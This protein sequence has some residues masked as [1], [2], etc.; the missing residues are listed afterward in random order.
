MGLGRQTFK[1]TVIY[2]IATAIG[3]LASF[4]MLPFY[5]HIF[6]AQGYGIIAM[7]DS[8]LGLLT[9]LLAGGFQTAILRIYHEQNIENKE[10]T[11][12]TGIALVWGLALLIVVFPLIFSSSI[13]ELILGSAEYYPIILLALITLVIDVAGQSASTIQIIKQQSLLFS[14]INLIQLI[15]GLLL[16]IWLVIFLEVGLI[17]IFISSLTTVMISSLIFHAIAFREHGFGFNLDIVLQLLK[18]QLPLLPGEIISFLGRQAERILVRVMIGLEEVGIL[19]MAYKFPPLIGLFVTIPFQRA[20]RTKSIEIAEQ[21]D[22][23][24]IISEMFTRYL[25]TIVFFGLLLG[26]TIQTILQLT[27][28]AEFWPA[29]SIAKIEIVTTILAGSTSYLSFGILYRKKTMVLSIIRLILTPTKILFSFVFIFI[30]GL[31]GAAYSA[32]LVEAITLI[33]ILLKAQSLYKLPLEYWKIFFIVSGA[34]ILFFVID[35]A[36]HPGIG[37]VMRIVENWISPFINFLRI[38][39]LEGWVS[40][41]IILVLQTKQT[42][43]SLLLLKIIFT[44]SFLILFPLVWRFQ[45]ERRLQRMFGIKII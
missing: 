11:L 19:E 45:P 40:E 1:H 18:F 10:I 33:W 31:K 42:Q 30:W 12:G 23:P 4:I 27:T 8:S 6:Q 13:S 9:V 17:G 44:L 25:F 35:T 43:I 37:V 2:S 41:K 36:S 3:R 38:I 32:F 20:W 21:S 16:N 34:F 29:V 14:I 7:I 28:P 39:F 22:A 24:Q 5:A 15:L 26:V